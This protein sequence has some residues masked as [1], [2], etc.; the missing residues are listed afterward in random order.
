MQKFK[1]LIDKPVFYQ[2]TKIIGIG[3]RI[4]FIVQNKSWSVFDFFQISQ[5]EGK[6]T[7]KGLTLIGINGKS[8]EN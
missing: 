3:P 5:K 8:Y 7:L 4:N 6:M 2:W 1:I